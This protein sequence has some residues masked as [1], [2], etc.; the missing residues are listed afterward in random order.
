MNQAAHSHPAGQ[1]SCLSRVPIFSGLDQPTTDAIQQLI[2]PTHYQKGETVQQSGSNQARLLV[3]NRGRAKIV[4]T[5]DDG[6]QQIVDWLT[7]GDFSG[8]VA[9]F[10]GLPTDSQIV[11]LE[12]SS[13]CTIDGPDL[14]S[15][16]AGSPDLAL[17]VI[18]QL[19]QRLSGSQQQ[20]ESLSLL[21]AEQKIHQRLVALAAG[22]TEFQLPMA[23]QDLAAE[24]GITPETLSR[25][26]KHLSDQGR[27]ALTGPRGI[28]LIDQFN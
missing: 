2:H 5:G 23:K 8:E 21:T 16:L 25:Q 14:K 13:F 22:Q 11:A 4:R 3:L 26:L 10:T 12:N 17:A 18:E 9:V 15:V 7:P 28:T 1:L 27:I 19:S 20:L 6:K 24:L